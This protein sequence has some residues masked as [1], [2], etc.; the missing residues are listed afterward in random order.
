[1][2]VGT[3]V[4]AAH[5]QAGECLLCFRDEFGGNRVPKLADTLLHLVSSAHVLLEGIPL[6]VAV[7]EVERIHDRTLHA[8]ALLVQRHV[9]AVGR[10]VQRGRK[11]IVNCER[12]SRVWRRKRGRGKT[13]RCDGSSNVFSRSVSS[14]ATRVAA[15]PGLVD[16]VP[17]SGPDAAAGAAAGATGSAAGSATAS[18]VGMPACSEACSGAASGGLF[19]ETVPS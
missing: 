1:M 4:G 15:A 11:P 9:H 19:G 10:H 7:F 8:Q 3:G 17:I 18:S 16:F 6:L 14:R 13:E 12:R 2:W 5:Q